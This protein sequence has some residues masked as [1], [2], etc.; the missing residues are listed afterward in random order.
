MGFLNSASLYKIQ[1]LVSKTGQGA[2]KHILQESCDRLLWN[3]LQSQMYN[4]SI[5]LSGFD[6]KSNP[7]ENI[8][9]LLKVA[10]VVIFPS[11]Q[12]TWYQA[13]FRTLSKQ[14]N[15]CGTRGDAMITKLYVCV[16]DN[17][18]CFQLKQLSC[19]Y[20]KL[21]YK[22]FYTTLRPHKGAAIFDRN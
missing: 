18:A 2:C 21:S 6:Q 10:V 4:F 7:I 16:H 13:L 15:V 5:S 11:I 8:F 9:D 20:F 12:M 3:K 22:F 17:Q 1:R 19:Y 14:S